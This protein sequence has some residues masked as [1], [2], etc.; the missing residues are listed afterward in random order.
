[1]SRLFM[2]TLPLPMGNTKGAL[3]C[4]GYV[5]ETHHGVKSFFPETMRALALEQLMVVIKSLRR[6]AYDPSR[7]LGIS[8]IPVPITRAISVDGHSF[9]YNRYQYISLIVYNIII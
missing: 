1:M 9:S 2:G 6:D 3:E 7:L 5:S 8:G 4:S